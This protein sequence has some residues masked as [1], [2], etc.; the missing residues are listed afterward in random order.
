MNKTKRQD[1]QSMIEELLRDLLITSLCIAGVKGK[2]VRK[3]VGCGMGRVTR[4]L[5][6]IERG[7]QR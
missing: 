1:D 4:I 5:K 7:R 6:H 2:E 3:I